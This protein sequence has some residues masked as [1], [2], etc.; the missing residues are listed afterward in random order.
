MNNCSSPLTP[1]FSLNSKAGIAWLCAVACA[2]SLGV[3]QAESDDFDDGNDSG[4]AHYNP[5]ENFGVPGVFSFA[6]GGYRIRTTSP[7]PDPEH[8]GNGRTGSLRATTY[9]DFYVSVDLVDWDDSLPQAVGIFARISTP[10]LGTTTGYAFTWSR[11][12][13]TNDAVLDITKITGEAPDDVPTSGSDQYYFVPGRQYR[14][15]FIGQGMRFEGRV[16]ELPDVVHPVVTIVG[17]DG[18]YTSGVNGLIV[19]DNSAAANNLTDAT[20]DDFIAYDIEPPRL[21]ITGPDS[22]GDIK[23]TWPAASFVGGFKLQS[24]TSFPATSWD[25]IPDTLVG[26]D[27]L[28]PEHVF[29][30]PLESASGQKFFRLRRP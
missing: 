6:D 12:V 14:L 29:Y 23:I 17:F 9:S 25:D 16:Y 28:D 8:L 13:E 26:T 21:E 19:Y 1:S 2:A 22:F 15:V 5:L 24:A 11:G 10:G 20:F 27:P 3:A 18:T 30:N 4:W 7:S